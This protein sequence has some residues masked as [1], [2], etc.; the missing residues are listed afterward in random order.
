MIYDMPNACDEEL[1][2]T[3]AVLVLVKLSGSFENAK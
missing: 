2:R 3:S 1:G